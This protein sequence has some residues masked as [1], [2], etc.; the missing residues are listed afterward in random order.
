MLSTTEDT[1]LATPIEGAGVNNNTVGSLVGSASVVP[2]N[3]GDSVTS[4][5][6]IGLALPSV[7]ASDT[8]VT[9]LDALPSA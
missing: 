9:G 6:A 8:S 5:L 2:S 4:G 3:F 1:T 7:P